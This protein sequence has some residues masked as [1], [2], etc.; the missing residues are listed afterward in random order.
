MKLKGKRTSQVCRLLFSKSLNPIRPIM[1]YRFFLFCFLF[2]IFL[3]AQIPPLQLGIETG[4]HLT[5]YPIS[6][7]EFIKAKPLLRYSIGMILRHNINKKGSGRKT[8]IPTARYGGFSIDYGLNVAFVGYNYQLEGIESYLDQ[9]SLEFPVVAVFKFKDS[10]FMSRKW[11]RKGMESYLRAGLKPSYLPKATITQT[12]I[13]SSKRLD[14]T[15]THGGWNVLFTY[16]FGL[17]QQKKNGNAASIGFTANLGFF[18]RTNTTIHY[19]DTS[20]QTTRQFSFAPAEMYFAV[21]AIFLFSTENI[22]VGQGVAPPRVYNPRG[23]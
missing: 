23:F 16:G 15:T 20:N 5:Y 6:D 10:V 18:K 11:K 8:Y 2:P 17:L 4:N 21:N 12:Q 9:V 19:H 7:Q 22:K 1:K 3:S 13:Q 14:E